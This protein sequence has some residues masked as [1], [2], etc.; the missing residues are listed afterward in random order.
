MPRPDQAASEGRTL[1]RTGLEVLK[2]S[3]KGKPAVTVLKLSAD[4]TQLSWRPHSYKKANR[5]LPISGVTRVDIGRESAAFRRHTSARGA[6][7]GQAHLS[8]SLVL[9]EAAAKQEGRDTLDLCAADEES[10]GLLVAALRALV[11]RPPPIGS[12]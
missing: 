6:G 3:R 10:F 9:H 12:P 4:E 8:L 1:L 2:F 5:R 7:I 11:G